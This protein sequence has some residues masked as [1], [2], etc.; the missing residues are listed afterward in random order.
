[1]DAAILSK[2]V[3]IVNRPKTENETVYYNVDYIHNAIYENKEIKFHYAEW[4]VKKK[5][6]S[7][8]LQFFGW[9]TGIGSGMKITGPENVKQQYKEYMLDV[10]QNY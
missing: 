1:M 6:V 10:L 2:Y 7:V 5:L 8:S 4:T 3:F 9:V